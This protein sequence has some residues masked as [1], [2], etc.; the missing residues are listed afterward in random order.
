MLDCELMVKV[1]N[2]LRKTE[3]FQKLEETYI[4][5]TTR[6]PIKEIA[7]GVGSFLVGTGIGHISKA[8]ELGN[9]EEALT[10]GIGITL[11]TA[12]AFMIPM[13]ISNSERYKTWESKDKLYKT[14]RNCY[15]KEKDVQDCVKNGMDEISVRESLENVNYNTQIGKI[16]DYEKDLKHYEVDYNQ[17]FDYRTFIVDE[18]EEESQQVINFEK[19]DIY[20]EVID[21]TLTECSDLDTQEEISM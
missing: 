7:V 18:P 3:Q 17:S 15:L 16:K 11:A 13:I 10:T 14:I 1:V 5:Q 21:D 19:I 2:H 4:K 9:V 20:N 12:G 8:M 6:K